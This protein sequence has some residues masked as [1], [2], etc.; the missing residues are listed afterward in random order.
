M[1]IA[2]FMYR[3]IEFVKELNVSC[4]KELISNTPTLHSYCNNCV[5]VS[6]FITP[7]HTEPPR[8][9]GHNSPVLPELLPQVAPRTG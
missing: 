8:P 2:L 5:V 7:L 9:S 6:Q 3:F 1:T 4:V